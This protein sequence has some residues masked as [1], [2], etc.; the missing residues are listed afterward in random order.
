MIT[1]TPRTDQLVNSLQITNFSLSYPRALEKAISL[2]ESLET[3]LSNR[4]PDIVKPITKSVE[5]LTDDELRQLIKDK[6][7][8]KRHE[9]D[10]HDL[11]G[12]S[13]QLVTSEDKWRMATDKIDKARAAHIGEKNIRKDMEKWLFH[14]IRARRPA[15]N[16]NADIVKP[17]TKSHEESNKQM[18]E[19]L[20][21]IANCL[22]AG[23]TDEWTIAALAK[24]AREAINEPTEEI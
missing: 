22:E 1:K 17:I 23:Q 21:K 20:S 13:M 8:F 5:Q 16:Q 24:I 2:C 3:E 4:S 11:A 18:L 9:I 12:F 10:Y 6:A 15:A 7:T 14:M 19:A